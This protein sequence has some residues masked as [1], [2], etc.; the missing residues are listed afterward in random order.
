MTIHRTRLFSPAIV[1]CA[2]LAMGCARG[3]AAVPFDDLRPVR[4]T[5]LASMGAWEATDDGAL[6]NVIPADATPETLAMDMDGRTVSLAVQEG[7]YARDVLIEGELSFHQGG[8][9]GL[10]FRV[11]EDE[12]VVEAM[13]MLVVSAQGVHLWRLLN[14]QWTPIYRHVTMLQEHTPV[15]LRA[16]A[17]G[18]RVR[19][20]LDGQ[21]LFEAQDTMLVQPGGVG[22]SAREGPCRIGAIRTASLD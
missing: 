3:P 1:F 17:V 10:L 16:E 21:P 20:W 18:P 9:P 4:E 12:G 19:V 15:T 11:Q 8:V 5:G 14:E 22:V 2:V 13:Y 7:F 6:A